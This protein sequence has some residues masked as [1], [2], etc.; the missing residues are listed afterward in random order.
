MELRM[1]WTKLMSNT[2]ITSIVEILQPVLDATPLPS[3]ISIQIVVIKRFKPVQG[4]AALGTVITIILPMPILDVLVVELKQKINGQAIPLVLD[5][6]WETIWFRFIQ[7][8]LIVLKVMK[9]SAINQAVERQ[10]KVSNLRLLL[11]NHNR[12]FFNIS[13]VISTDI[14]SPCV[15]MC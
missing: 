6:E 5:G 15:C 9:L 7:N 4:N 2:Y 14:S 10:K 1:G 12:S 11:F 3:I 13:F 8:S